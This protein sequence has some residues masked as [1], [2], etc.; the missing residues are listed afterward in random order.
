LWANTRAETEEA[1]IIDRDSDRFVVRVRVR[2]RIWVRVG[3]R[4]R[5]R[6]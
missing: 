1:G 4:A 3:D 6:V 5:V 2:V